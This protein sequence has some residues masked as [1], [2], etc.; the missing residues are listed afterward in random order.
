MTRPVLPAPVSRPPTRIEATPTSNPSGPL[1]IPTTPTPLEYPKRL[2]NAVSQNNTPQQPPV[3]SPLE[4]A[5][6]VLQTTLEIP[7]GVKS[8]ILPQLADKI[9]RDDRFEWITG[10]L[11][12]EAGGYFLY[13]A[14]PD[15]V[16]TYDGRVSLHPQQLDMSSYRRGDLVSVRGELSQRLTPEGRSPVYRASDI[17]LLERVR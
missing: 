9:G 5:T 4:S 17:Q 12:V 13:Y 10:Q 3:G 15:T 8:P 7:G 6:P 1:V 16:D 2:P 11:E 14:T